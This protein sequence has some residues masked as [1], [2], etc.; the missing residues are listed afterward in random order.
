MALAAHNGDGGGGEIE[1]FQVGCWRR[2]ENDGRKREY[3]GVRWRE[4][5]C[6]VAVL[7][8]HQIDGRKRDCGGPRW[9]EVGCNFA[10]LAAHQDDGRKREC[11]G[12]G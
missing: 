8:G 12:V 9:R 6:S 3:A 1:K 10:V 2:T 11:G 4:V 5:G 7:A